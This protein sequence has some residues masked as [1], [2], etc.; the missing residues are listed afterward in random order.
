LTENFGGSQNFQQKNCCAVFSPFGTAVKNSRLKYKRNSHYFASRVQEGSLPHLT[1]HAQRILKREREIRVL[2]SHLGRFWGPLHIAPHIGYQFDTKI[3]DFWG[4]GI[5][6]KFSPNF[7]KKLHK[8]CAISYFLRF[9][10]KSQK[11][12]KIPIFTL[13]KK[14]IKI[15]IFPKFSRK[16]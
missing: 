12:P 6:P 2:R 14:S 16:I 7:P 5:S 8:Y 3:W 1:A 11:H 13:F 10:K 15:T 4:L 9:P